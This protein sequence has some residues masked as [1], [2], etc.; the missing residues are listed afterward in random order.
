MK[1]KKDI[2]L[3]FNQKLGL[4]FSEQ[5]KSNTLQE[6]IRMLDWVLRDG[7]KVRSIEEIGKEYKP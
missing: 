5:F 7:Y 1:S 6:H 2:E 4:L 3:N